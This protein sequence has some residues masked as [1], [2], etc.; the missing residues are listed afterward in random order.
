MLVRI[1]TN[2]LNKLNYGDIIE[3]DS[4]RIRCLLENGEAEIVQ[5]DKGIEEPVLADPIPEEKPKEIV[6][7]PVEAPVEIVVK[8]KAGRPK[9]VK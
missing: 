9:K 8:K 4:P 5:D 1:I 2:R 7:A 6:E 3:E